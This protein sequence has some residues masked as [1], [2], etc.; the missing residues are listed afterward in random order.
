VDEQLCGNGDQ[1]GAAEKALDP[2][3]PPPEVIAERGR[4]RGVHRHPYRFALR[5]TA[6]PADEEPVSGEVDVTDLHPKPLH[7]PESLAQ[8]EQYYEAQVTIVPRDVDQGADGF[9]R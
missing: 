3:V 7:S 4:Q 1:R 2:P 6:L 8:A 9:F 5:T